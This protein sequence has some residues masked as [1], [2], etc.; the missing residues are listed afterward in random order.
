MSSIPPAANATSPAFGDEV[1]EPEEDLR[2]HGIGRR[3]QRGAV[4][5]D[6]HVGDAV[7]REDAVLGIALVVL[8]RAAEGEQPG[9]VHRRGAQDGERAV[10]R[11]VV[12]L[13]GRGERA[14]REDEDAPRERGRVV[15]V[16]CGGGERDDARVGERRRAFDQV[17]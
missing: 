5:G 2:V 16:E 9:C 12:Q 7:E 13:D 15:L 17:A 6:P 10:R 3:N 8:G 4:G 1:A 11:R 14:V